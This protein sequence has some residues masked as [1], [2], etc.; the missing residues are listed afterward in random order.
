MKKK[1]RFEQ[2]TTKTPR[3]WSEWLMPKM[4]GYLLKCCDCGLTHELQF[5]V[6]VLSKHKKQRWATI[7][8]DPAI[9]V[10]FRAKRTKY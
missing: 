6:V 2:V 3:S 9:Q 10:E 1:P 8:E 5:R 4:K 7:L